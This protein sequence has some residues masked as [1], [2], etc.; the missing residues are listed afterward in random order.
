MPGV[1]H[2]VFV[3]YFLDSSSGE[4]ITEQGTGIADFSEAVQVA[5]IVGDMDTH[6]A[7]RSHADGTGV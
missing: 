6:F 7:G 2:A 4:T 1:G 3:P 5:Q